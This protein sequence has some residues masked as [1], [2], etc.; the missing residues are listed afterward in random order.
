MG[1][2][3]ADW[4][5]FG[6]Q[7]VATGAPRPLAELRLLAPV[8]R[9]G[10]IICVGLN[11]RDHAR[12]TRQELPGAGPVLQV[13][14]SVV[15]PGADVLVPPRRRR[16]TTRPSWPWSSAGGPAGWPR[17][18]PS[19]TSPATP[20]PTTC[21]RARSSSAPPSGCWARR[22]TPSCR[23]ARTWSRPTRCP[24]RRPSASAAGSTTS[25]ARTRTPGDGV[26]GGRA[27]Q[28]H[29]PDHHPGTGRPARHRHPVG[30]GMAADPPRFLRAGDRMRVE[31]DGLGELDNTV[32]APDLVLA[33]TF[34]LRGNVGGLP[35]TRRMSAIQATDLVRRFGE[36]ELSAASA[37]RSPRARSTASLAPT[38]PASR[39]SS[40]S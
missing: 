14:N 24:T 15:G 36:V 5:A 11:Y 2:S 21:P 30:V 9:P 16:S 7:S 10:K 23:S 13:P 26:R 39:P 32:R 38:G 31:I 6:T 20:A 37:S 22:S 34:Y 19:T 3:L 40:A 33:A 17:P 4:L 25:C 18:P 1:P 27:G 12:E 8:P 29:Q 28:L 35:Y